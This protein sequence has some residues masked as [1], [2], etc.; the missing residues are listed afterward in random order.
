M[1]VCEHAGLYIWNKSLLIIY[2]EF[3]PV[4]IEAT[5]TKVFRS[6]TLAMLG[7][8]SP[9]F[10]LPA[11][12]GNFRGEISYMYKVC[13]AIVHVFLFG[14]LLYVL[15]LVECTLSCLMAICRRL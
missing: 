11:P 13:I 3:K 10:L 7:Q 2:V 5:R 14:H 12:A 6:G 4:W 8:I 15:T 1:Y 9:S